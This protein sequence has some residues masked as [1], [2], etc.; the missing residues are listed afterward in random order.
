MRLAEEEN[1]KHIEHEGFTFS[2]DLSQHERAISHKCTSH[3]LANAMVFTASTGSLVEVFILRIDLS[4]IEFKKCQIR[5][6]Y[7]VH[8]I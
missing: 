5:S 6:T 1:I 7:C 4:V 3:D 8:A 2:V